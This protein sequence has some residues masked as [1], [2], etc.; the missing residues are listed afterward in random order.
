M[1]STNKTAN[2]QLSQFVGTD[3]PSILTDYNGDMRKIDT[4]IKEIANA[5]GSNASDISELQ[6]IVGQHTTEISGINSSISTLNGKVL[7]IEDKIPSNASESNKLIT[8]EDIP[9]IPDI[10]E[11]EADVNAIKISVNAIED[12]IPNDASANNKLVTSSTITP[13]NTTIDEHTTKIG[14][15]ETND[16]DF[17]E[18]ISAL[19]SGL[20]IIPMGVLIATI[21][22]NTYDNDSDLALAL[23][24]AIDDYHYGEDPAWYAKISLVI[25]DCVY[26]C[27]NYHDN[28]PN[29]CSFSR[30]VFDWTNSGNKPYIACETINLYDGKL[31]GCTIE[32]STSGSGASVTMN[33]NSTSLYNKTIKIFKL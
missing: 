3:I 17:E 25:D 14:K 6:S 4:A 29:Q 1:S 32:G 11:L 20:D 5:E 26:R 15:L 2:Y 19:E 8:A 24:V 31:N 21:E 22:A 16:E 10:E 28:N 9:E 27:T 13:I 18:R 7:G 30:T 23:K 33:S 12:K